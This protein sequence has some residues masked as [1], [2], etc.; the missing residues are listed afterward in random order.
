MTDPVHRQ[1][2]SSPDAARAVGFLAEMRRLERSAPHKPRIGTNLK[3]ADEL[4]A[5][6]QDPFPDFPL[7][8]FTHADPETGT[9]RLAFFGYY[10]SHG[11][12]PP[13]LR[14]EVA[15]WQ[16]DG[17][18]AFVALTDMLMTRFA[19]HY[20]RAWRQSN[21]IAQAE[22]PDDD[23]FR[24][25]LSALAGR[26]LPRIG[27]SDR[28]CAAHLRSAVKSPV[29]LRQVL[30]HITGELVEI[31]EHEPTWLPIAPDNQN[32]MGQTGMTL[33][34]DCWIGDRAICMNTRIVLKICC[35]SYEAYYDLLP[36]TVGHARL[37]DTV[38]AFLGQAYEVELVL[39]L[40]RKDLPAAK[41]GNDGS[42]TGSQLGWTAHVPDPG[43]T[44][45]PAGF[46]EATRT[47]LG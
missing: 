34:T 38:R 37:C 5:L 32:S 20:Y 31:E 8:D 44:N 43:N 4:A 18:D 11:P 45:N 2:T 36:G 22:R 3:R 23:G 29:R 33:G 41:L 25:Q 27:D 47:L 15:A 21:A 6:G 10:G 13:I 26:L 46:V 39:H 1:K 30:S 7:S 14:D 28:G 40:R 17:N 24:A 12:I 35:E 42:D 19:Q 9:Y 16:L